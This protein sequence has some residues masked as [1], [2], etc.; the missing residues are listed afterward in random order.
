MNT[1]YQQ[2]LKTAEEAVKGIRSGDRVF[3]GCASSISY[4]LT[5]ALWERRGELEN[6]ELSTTNLM[7][8]TPICGKEHSPFR[9]NSPFLGPGERAA[10]KNGQAVSFTSFHLSQVDIWC[11]R[12]MKPDVCFLEVTPPDAEGYMSYGPSGGCLNTY[13]LES[14]R[15]VIAHVNPQVPYVTGQVCRIHLSKVDIIVEADDTLP[16]A[17]E[18]PVDEVTRRISEN[19]LKLVPDGATIQLGI[20]KLSTAIGYGLQQHNDLGVYSELFNDP[21]MH[22]IKNGNVTNTKKGYIDGLSV[23]SFAVGS[24]ELYEFMDHNPTLYCGTFPFVN[25][26]RNIAKNRRMISINSAM[27]IDLYGQVAADSLGWKQQS[28]VGG[29]I[30]F[31][32][33]AQWSEEGKSF[34]ATASSFMKG[35]VRQSKIMLNFPVGTA[36]TTARSEVQY[37]ATEYGCVD[38][39]ELS[40]AN[41]VKAMISL[42]H[43]DFRDQLT[44]DARSHHLI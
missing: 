6:V 20:G 38:L 14:A 7:K 5:Q 33:G 1:E 21:L 9:I 42:A 35:G 16:Q 30:D 22:L 23:F 3:L 40:M 18:E 28:A 36:I 15:L 34:I 32:K 24:K 12:M 27:A 11:R 2:K 26:A 4:V 43:P 19:I 25:D 29:Q 41:R 10:V 31:V 37:V 44:E 17:V 39:K 8:P 13:M